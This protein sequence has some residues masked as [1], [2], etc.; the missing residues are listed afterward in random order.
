MVV[1]SLGMDDLF[2]FTEILSKKDYINFEK[3]D[4]AKESII[5]L[6]DAQARR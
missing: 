5:D 4:G 2:T 6:V 1:A 3:Q